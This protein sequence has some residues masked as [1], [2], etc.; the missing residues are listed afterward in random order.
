MAKIVDT[1]VDMWRGTEPTIRATVN[2]L[3][4]GTDREFYLRINKLGAKAQIDKLMTESNS[5]ST[6]V[7]LSVSL[8]E[9]ET[10]SIKQTLADFEIVCTN[11][12][13]V[14]LEGKF[15]MRP[16]IRPAD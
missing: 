13:D 15:N 6:S 7:D 4:G 12:I 10:N 2:V 3:G 1:P 5:T 14:L 8:T 16:M 11:P 9:S